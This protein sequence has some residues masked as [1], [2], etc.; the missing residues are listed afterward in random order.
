MIPTLENIKYV[1]RYSSKNTQLNKTA[2][3]QVIKTLSFLET[4]GNTEEIVLILSEI[5]HKKCCKS[6]GYVK[7]VYM[8]YG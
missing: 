6:L 7:I 8:I 3:R 2:I 4:N 1:M 5:N